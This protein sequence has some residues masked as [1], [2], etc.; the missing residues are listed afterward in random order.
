[1]WLASWHHPCRPRSGGVW[2]NTSSQQA[3][4]PQASAAAVCAAA[5]P[6]PK[7]WP[8]RQNR[9][10]LP[11]V[12][13]QSSWPAARHLRLRNLRRTRRRHKRKLSGG[14]RSFVL[15]FSRAIHIKPENEQEARVAVCRPP[16]TTFP[17]NVRSRVLCIQTTGRLNTKHQPTNPAPH[18]YHTNNPKKQ[19]TGAACTGPQN[20]TF[21]TKPLTKPRLS[22]GSRER[23]PYLPLP[24]PSSFWVWVWLKLVSVALAL[25]ASLKSSSRGCEPALMPKIDMFVSWGRWRERKLRLRTLYLSP[26]QFCGFLRTVELPQPATRRRRRKGKACVERRRCR[27]AQDSGHDGSQVD[28]VGAQDGV[29]SDSQ[30]GQVGSQVV[31]DSVD[32]RGSQSEITCPDGESNLDGGVC[33]SFGYSLSVST[34]CPGWESNLDGGVCESFGYSQTDRLSF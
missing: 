14:D 13:P 1:M 6:C 34:I 30:G 9:R 15:G 20:H 7:P 26:E 23:A 5:A 10:G 4:R 19:H 32:D 24:Y 27:R 16:D 2:Y 17:P 8:R 22:N 3:T 31:C 18:T 11:P 25:M 12:R 21:L 28:S 33:E 29:G